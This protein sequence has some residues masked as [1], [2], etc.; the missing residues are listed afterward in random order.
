[1]GAVVH[2]QPFLIRRP[3]LLP[4]LG[5][6]ANQGTAWMSQRSLGKDQVERLGTQERFWICGRTEKRSDNGAVL[7]NV[8]RSP[9]AR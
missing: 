1:M 3:P 5:L 7:E 2:S 9:R 8:W 6:L 4:I